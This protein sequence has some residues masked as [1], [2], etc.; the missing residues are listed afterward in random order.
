MLDNNTPESKEKLQALIFDHLVPLLILKVVPF[1][2]FSEF[3]EPSL[4]G[5]QSECNKE[6]LST[7]RDLLVQT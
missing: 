3:V 6:L 2:H 1:F 4:N 7:L 5:G